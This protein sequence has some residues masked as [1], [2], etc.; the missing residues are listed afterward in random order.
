MRLTRLVI[1]FLLILGAVLVISGEQLSGANADAVINARLTTLRAPI[2]GTLSVER[3]SLGTRVIE[4]EAIGSILD[5]IADNSRLNDLIRERAFAA[6]EVER[7]IGLERSISGMVE[8]LRLRSYTYRQ[9][10]VRQLQAQLSSAQSQVAAAQAR[11]EETRSTLE[12][13]QQLSDRGLETSAVFGRNQS[14]VRVADLELEDARQRAAATEISLQCNGA[15]LPPSPSCSGS[16]CSVSFPIASP[17]GMPETANS[18]SSSGPSTTSS[19]L[20]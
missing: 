5:P 19:C 12:R 9:E 10:R 18:S 14:S 2:A 8:G 4:G 16:R 7:L 13:S 17:S 15:C 3:R 1:G 11:L 6:A 20:Q